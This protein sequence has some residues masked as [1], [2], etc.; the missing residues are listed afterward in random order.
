MN[1][2]TH[3]CYGT[4]HFF[5]FRLFLLQYGTVRFFFIKTDYCMNRFRQIKLC[6]VPFLLLTAFSHIQAATLPA[7]ASMTLDD[8][9]H[10]GLERSR[11]LEI[12][13]LDRDMTSQK[14]R[15][16]WAQVL[17]QISSDFT[18]TRSLKPSV[19]FFPDIFNGGT[20]NS[21][22]P[23]VISADNAATATINV[24]Q[25]LFNGSAFAGIKAAG[26]LRKMSNEAYR[27]AEAAVIADIKMSYFDALIS[28]DQLKL[29][30]QSIERWQ[31]SRKDTRAMFRQ[32]VAA[33]IDTL[34][35][36][37][38]VENLRPDLIQAENRVATT[39]T[40]LKNVIGIPLDSTVI[41]SGKLELSS[42]TY[43]QDIA[44]A[45]REALDS[46]PDLRQLDLQVKAEGE[47]VS[48]ARAERYPV[49]SAFGQFESQTA[50]N[51]N[52]KTSESR[53]PVSTA[54]GLEVSLPIFTGY[55]TSAQV[56]QARITQMQTRTR[57]EDLKDAIRAEVEVRL[58]NFRE[59]QKRIDVQSKTISVAERSYKISLLRFKEGIGTRLE[60]TD[61]ELQLNKAKTNYLQA[62]Y[63]Y[64][65]ASV[66]LD[67]ALGRSETSV[68]A[69]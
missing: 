15:E 35:A 34:K 10:I 69:K 32:G 41:L 26:I 52:V 36:Y 60:L 21:F 57:V 64:L 19:L 20:S 3:N 58:L 61:A 42:A 62:V 13:R 54:V 12:A 55:R 51:D 31:Q 14:I 9:V 68:S 59:S 37:L 29:I 30:E 63:D 46:R 43:P 38:S 48:A 40:K 44:A 39:M 56:E 66:Q 11:M 6:I 65:V 23:L 45:Y 5:I 50:F 4:D 1:V 47:K 28:R 16:T 2:T 27:N 33:D 67:K 49:I 8:A 25:A 24:R 7:N 18:Y 22:I 17:P 53:W